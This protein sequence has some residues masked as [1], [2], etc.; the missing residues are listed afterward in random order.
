M[1][2]HVILFQ[3]RNFH[4]AHKHVFVEETNLNASDDDSFNDKVSSFVIL[5]GFWTFWRDIHFKGSK[6]QPLGP[7]EYKWVGD[8]GIQ[9]DTVSS[10]SSLR[11]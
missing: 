10:L 11:H 8:V 1:T 2:A 3:H 4:G 5:D 9:N 6:S 7:G